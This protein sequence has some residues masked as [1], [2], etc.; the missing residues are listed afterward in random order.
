MEHPLPP[1]ANEPAG[2]NGNGKA[3][4]KKPCSEQPTARARVAAAASGRLCLNFSKWN[5]RWSPTRLLR[6]AAAG[7]QKQRGH[8]AA[9]SPDRLALPG[10]AGSAESRRYPDRR[11][12]NFSRSPPL[13]ADCCVVNVTFAPGHHQ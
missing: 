7:P 3:D 12:S 9:R 8:L 11:P 6:E 13:A 5:N 4:F 2:A 10:P 1:I